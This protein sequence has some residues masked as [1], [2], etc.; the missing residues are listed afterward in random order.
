MPAKS[1][2]GIIVWF[3]CFGLQTLQFIRFYIAKTAFY[4]DMPKYLAGHERIPFQERVLPI[5]FLEP[6]FRSPWIMRFAHPNG[7]FTPELGPFYVLSLITFVI[8]GI[9]VQKLYSALTESGTLFFIVYPLFLFAAMWSYVIHIEANL[10]YPYDMP[11]VAFFAA[12]LYL[13]YTRKF[14]PLLIVMF[15]GTLNRETTLFLIGIFIIDAASVAGSGPSTRF[16]DRFSL[17]QVP[18]L[19]VAALASIWL[20]IKITLAHI[21]AGN[22]NSENFVRFAYNL[23]KMGPRLWPA[24]LNICGYMLPIVWLLR[25]NIAPVRFANYLYIMPF[26][27]AIMFYTG[28][29]I[30]TRIY[31]ELC[32]F[33]AVALVLISERLIAKINHQRSGQPEMQFS[34]EVAA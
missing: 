26:W 8:A 16:R 4:L 15:L 6:V 23:N 28:V 18:W 25:G 12:G 19:R 10:S 33:V 24:M 20:A 7:L 5:L 11:S 1:R 30:E 13:I 34:E 27:F 9:F 22:D 29:V 3:A 32:S 17:H 2:V 14:I 31:G 21:F